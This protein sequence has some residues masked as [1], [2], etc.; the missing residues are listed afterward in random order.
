MR[1][2]AELHDE[3]L[4]RIKKVH[5]GSFKGIDM[6][7]FLISEQYIGLWLEHVYDSLML[8]KLEPEYLFAA[9]NAIH[10]FIDRQKENGHLPF[11][12]WDLNR[13]KIPDFTMADTAR[14]WQIQEGVSFFTLA[15]EVYELNQ[16][17]SFLEKVYASG[18]KWDR[19][20]RTFRMTT[21]RGLI[22]MFVGYDTGHDNSGRLEGLSC[23]GN[24]SVDGVPQ[25]AE[26]LPPND[27]IAPILA[28]DMNCSFY[29]DE[30]ALAR[31]AELLGKTEEATRWNES[32]TMIKQKLFEH[33]FDEE[34]AFFYDVDKNGNKR[35]YKSSAIL[36]LFL[37]KVLDP[38]TDRV[39]IDRIYR[40]HLKNPDEFWT[41]FPFPSMAMN[42]PSVE[43]H[44]T[45][46]CWG[47]YTQALI[48]LR[49]S[50]WM[51]DYGYGDDYD[52][53]LGKWLETWTVHYDSL[54][55]GQE[56]DP[57]TGLP[58]ASSKFYSSSMLTYIYAAR[59]LGWV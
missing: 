23:R 43:G 1:K 37:E 4:D 12:V 47:Y 53:I 48:V 46:N 38:E 18:V 21:Q 51:D 54:P 45:F 11:A 29:A 35:K 31:M 34:D 26:V 5:I 39:L 30:K 25:S 6:P 36:H 19:W 3:A 9:E 33:C 41:P 28:V 56:I 17:M 32:A 20:L 49:C 42:D 7:L 24:Y 27:E 55:F 57:I 10:L 58:T 14:Y 52:Y 15:L 59:R 22:E 16:D 50:R 2:I 40:E 44:E 8:A 13:V